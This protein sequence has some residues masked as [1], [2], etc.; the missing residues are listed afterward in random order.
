[1][2]GNRDR[3]CEP[4]R[5]ICETM[6]RFDDCEERQDFDCGCDRRV[7]KHRHIVKHQH[8]IINEYDVLHEHHYNY[9]DVVKTREIEKHNDHRHHKPDYCKDGRCEFRAE[10]N[11]V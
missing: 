2:N 9:Y 10:E 7:I 4:R 1:M 3:C 11:Q 5:D 6:E 8:D